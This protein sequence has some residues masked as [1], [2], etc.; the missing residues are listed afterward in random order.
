M[1]AYAES[2]ERRANGILTLH[3]NGT[4]TGT[5]TKWKVWCHV[6][7]FTVVRYRDGGLG[8]IVSY[9]ISLVPCTSPCPVTVQCD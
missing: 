6:E 7:I 8:L 3:G 9:C 4:G 5:G 1:D 2:I